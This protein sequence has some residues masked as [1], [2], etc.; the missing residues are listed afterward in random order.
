MSKLIRSNSDDNLSLSPISK[1]IH[2]KPTSYGVGQ[3]NFGAR[4]DSS[5]SDYIVSSPYQNASSAIAVS[6]E[7]NI[8]RRILLFIIRL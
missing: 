2:S 5:S 4:D 8:F 3:R 1:I 7:M 6:F